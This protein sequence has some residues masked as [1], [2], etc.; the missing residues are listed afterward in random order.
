MGRR[1]SKPCVFK[2]L[3]FMELK[4]NVFPIDTVYGS[5]KDELVEMG[6]QRCLENESYVAFINTY[7][8][9][10]TERVE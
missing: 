6:R 2:L 7:T 4:G 10:D 5:D 8:L 9:S 3:L 1:N